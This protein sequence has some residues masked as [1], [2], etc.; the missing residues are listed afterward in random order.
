[1]V[2]GWPDLTA[3]AIHRRGDLRVRVGRRPRRGR[4]PGRRPVPRSGLDA[5]EVPESGLGAAVAEADAVV[6]EAL[7]MG[8]G[9]FV[10]VAGSR[11]AAA[12]ARHAGIPI[13]ATVGEGRLLPGRL[14]EALLSRLDSRGEPWDAEHE[15]VPLDLID[16][17]AGPWGTGSTAE[18]LGH[19]DCPVAPELFKGVYAPGTYRGRP[20]SDARRRMGWS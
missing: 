2:L 4:R 10:A 9:G 19:T 15:V 12:V 5:V 14:L 20:D 17:V 18:A 8:P 6:I 1:M 16:T 11:A 7:A 13:W 3:Q